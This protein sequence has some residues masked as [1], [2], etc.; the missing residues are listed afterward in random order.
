M[1]ACV[2]VPVDD[3]YRAAFGRKRTRNRLADTGSSAGDDRDATFQVEV[4]ND[5]AAVELCYL[6]STAMSR[7]CASVIAKT[8]SAL[9]ILTASTYR[10]ISHGLLPPIGKRA[11]AMIGVKPLA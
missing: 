6:L 9:T 4:H 10:Q 2:S 1:A 11:V 5:R 3:A 7:L 8:D